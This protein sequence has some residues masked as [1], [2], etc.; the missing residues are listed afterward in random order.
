M[1]TMDEIRAL[2]AEL[3]RAQQS[4][5]ISRLSERNCIQ[6]VMKLKELKLI[7]V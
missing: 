6:L 5:S 4:G 3:Q 2:Q 1:A 7:E